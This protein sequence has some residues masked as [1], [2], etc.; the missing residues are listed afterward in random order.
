MGEI[1]VKKFKKFISLSLAGLMLIPSIAFAKEKDYGSAKN[2]I[3]MIP[4]G[5]SVETVT[6]AR[7]IDEDNHLTM[8][9]ML[10]GL[11][12]IHNSNT[13][14]AD[15]APAGTAMSTGIKTE[16]PY[17]ASYPSKSGLPNSVELDKEK[18][19]MPI[20]TI[21]EG[22]KNIGKATGIVSTSNIQHATPADFSSHYP[23]RNKY[24]ILG[25]QQVYQKMDLVLGAGSKYLSKEERADKEDLISEIKNLGYEYVT[26][27]KGLKN[28]KTNKVWGMFDPSAM[29]Y[30]VDRDPEKEPA[31]C[32][33]TEKALQVLSK[34]DKGFFLMVEGSEVDWGNH[35]NDPVGALKDLLAFDKAVKVAKDFAD[36]NKDTV[37]IIAADHGTGGFTFGNK[38]ISKGYD[39]APLK[40]FVDVIRFSKASAGKT[41]EM[42]KADRNKAQEIMKNIYNIDL[43]TEEFNLLKTVDEK[44]LDGEIANIVSLNSNVGWTTGGHTAGD[45]GLYCYSTSENAKVLKGL[46]NNCDIGNYMA[47]LFNIDLQE[48][49]DKF[50][51]KARKEFEKI[52]AE[53]EFKN[54]DKNPVLT[55]KKGDK[56]L[57]IPMYK[58]YGIIGG[59]K[60]DLGS[61]SVF[62][63][64]KVYVSQKAI[65]LLK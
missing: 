56:V 40:D 25:E 14:I 22:A 33:M 10:T 27:T 54:Q 7:W 39:K 24:E 63:G 62:N 6:A 45:V 37:I 61:V 53:I 42:I 31:L 19:N 64:S 11:V 26:D 16:T 4:D 15:S 52:G 60:I 58:N 17:I 13:P 1:K 55:A 35:A 41:A 46:I 48:M 65:D 38:K 36:K 5:T 34:N 23:N 30:D 51:L 49:T 57:V 18:I 44:K 8:D 59:E 32:E 21:L 12:K 20:A 28:A 29:S 2:I 50:F 3:M 9:E 43:S 47:D